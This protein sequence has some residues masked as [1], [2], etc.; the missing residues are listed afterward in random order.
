MCIYQQAGTGP[1]L[2]GGA[3]S[4]PADPDGPET[5]IIIT[6]ITITII[7]IIITL[8]WNTILQLREGEKVDQEMF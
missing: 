1:A 5:I 4:C 6:T 3:R 2:A 7:T 8:Y